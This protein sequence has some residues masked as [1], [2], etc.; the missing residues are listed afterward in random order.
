MSHLAHH[1]NLIAGQW[2]D[3]PGVRADINPSD[4]TDVVG[5]YSTADAEQA[6][7]AVAAVA[8]AAPGWAA[9]PG[10]ARGEILDRA[11]T[12]LLGR[13]A[14]LG[15]QLAREEGKTLPE[16]VA[17]VAR[18]GQLLKFH[19][20]QALRNAGEHLDS[21][22]PGVEVTV[23]REP[24]G[25]VSIITPWNF[26][27]AIPAWKIAPALAYGNTVVFKPA[28]SVPASAWALVD[29]LHR[30]GLPPG[31]LNLVMGRGR[32]IGDILTGSPEVGAISLT[33][34]VSTGERVLRAA[35]RRRARVQ[36]EMGGKNPLIIADD[37]DL[38]LA[39]EV[40]L[41][42]SYGS[43]GQR[44]TASSR[45]VVADRLHDEFVDKLWTRLEKW[46]VGDARAEGTDMGP[47]VDAQ[48]LAQDLHYIEIARKEGAQLLGGE[49]LE[50]ERPGYYLQPAL[51]V[52]TG[53][54]DT[55]NREEIFGPVASVIRVADYDEAVS[56]ANDT[57]FGLTA[58]I[59]TRSLARAG[60]FRRRS[61]AGMVMVNVPTAG[62]DF[63]VPFGG[64]GASSY[65]PRE[66]GTAARE[67]FTAT[68]TSYIAAGVPD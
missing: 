7:E 55:V 19:A 39:V 62:V 10:A 31:V 28:E 34:S 64:R 56:V 13:S 51:L 58:G 30:A 67:F 11:G 36:L 3:G 43:T 50:R 26:P 29:A 5:Y 9:T 40:A 49:Q 65:G 1:P 60:D 45:L 37:A 33:G 16:A 2:R 12:E 32:D 17:E 27:I 59:V 23:T 57:E 46:Q 22:R 35:T 14:E 24:V 42:G 18:A 20:G 52:G 61:T 53:N 8:A 4:T 25:V 63:H 47:V 41:H 66:Q 68:K 54:D 6:G 44:C 15:E 21:V 48:Q 38:D